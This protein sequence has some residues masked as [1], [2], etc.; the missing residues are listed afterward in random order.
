[1]MA[2]FR[3]V[4]VLGGMGPEA[5]VLLQ[6]RLIAAVSAQDDADHIPLLVDMNPQV[7]SR[8]DWILKGQG[9]DPGAVLAAMARR[10]E[11]AGAEALVMPCNT[12]HH[13][14][15]QIT[16]AVAIPFLHMV[17]ETCARAAEIAGHGGTV[18]ILASPATEEIGLFNNAFAPLGVTPIVP[19]DRAA[20]LA[21]IRRIKSEGPTQADR[22]LLSEAAQ[23]CRVAGAGC[24]LVGCSEY[25]LIADAAQIGLPVLDSL[26]VQVEQIISFAMART[27]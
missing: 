11:G 1:M 18:G 27:P 14:A 8:L 6:Q 16:A 20:M 23:E 19:D 22:T 7:P 4:G 13:F 5:T 15:P 25:S 26:D 17:N 21:S 12:A 10:L 2:K 3:T 24:L 9:D